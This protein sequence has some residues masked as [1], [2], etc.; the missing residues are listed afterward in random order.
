[1]MNLDFS[2]TAAFVVRAAWF[3]VY[4]KASRAMD[5]SVG[6]A[7]AEEEVAVA[8]AA[9]PTTPALVSCA[10]MSAI[11]ILAQGFPAFFTGAAAGVL[12]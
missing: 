10:G 11:L 8:V 5:A 2:R 12:K 1:M 4:T 9:C 7:A 3:P 6:A